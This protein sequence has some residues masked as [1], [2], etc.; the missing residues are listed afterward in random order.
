[1][2]QQDERRNQF[3][4]MQTGRQARALGRAKAPGVGRGRSR[5]QLPLEDEQ[6]S[7][8]ANRNDGYR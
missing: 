7:E 3:N 8:K 5:G 4:K 2:T 1:M 6:R